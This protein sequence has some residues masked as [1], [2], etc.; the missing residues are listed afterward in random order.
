MIP[1][2]L[3]FVDA[4]VLFSRTLR[5]WICLLALH[6]ACTAYDLRWSE[7]VLAEWMY[8]LRRRNP[9]HTDQAIGGRRRELE[10]AF[11]AAMVRG[12]DPA[13]V[14]ELADPHDRH[15]LAAALHGRADMLVTDDR[16]ARFP[17]AVHHRLDVYTADEFL[18]WVAES[19][20]GLVTP[21]LYQQLDYYHRN[22]I[23]TG[24]RSANDLVVALRKARAHRFAGH[25]ERLLADP[26]ASAP[27]PP[28]TATPTLP[29][30]TP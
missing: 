22:A 5:D 17:D 28:G 3:V 7:D 18:M 15:V 12:Y 29:P 8:R 19:H 24:G 9:G 4:N 16:E 21:V 20:A 30:R 26:G 6:S 25:L 2:P 13:T 10:A 23:V 27:A 14:P 1:A 11:P